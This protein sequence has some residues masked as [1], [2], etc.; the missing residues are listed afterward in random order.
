MKILTITSHISSNSH[1][2][3]QRN[4]TGFG[5]MVHDI[6]TSLA[7]N[8]N[9]VDV[10][11][12]WYRFNKLRLDGADYL[13]CSIWKILI[14]LFSCLPICYLIKHY[15]K[16]PVS[17]GAT[18]RMFYCWMLTGYY[19]RIIRKNNYDIVHIHGCG[20]NEDFFVK[21]CQQ[22]KQ[23]YVVTLH[24][25]NSFNESVAMEPAGKRYERDFLHDVVKGY[26]HITVIA[27]GIKKRILE[28]EHVK[29]SC[30]ID[31][32]CNAF[33]F[34]VNNK[35]IIDIREKIGIPQSAQLI[36][37]VGNLGVNKNQRQMVE[38][39]PLINQN[40]RANTYVLFIG[41]PSQEID[42]QGIIDNSPFKDQLIYAG[43]VD[44]ADI[45]AYYES[46][47]ATVLLSF[48]EGF[49]LSLVEG[50]H[51]G[52]PCAMFCDMDAYQDIYDPCAVIGI[53]KRSNHEVALGIE[54]L[55][56]SNWNR[57]SIRNYSSRFGADSM[58]KNYL[59]VFQS[60]LDNSPQ[61][62]EK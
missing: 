5:Y 53:P 62:N 49:G 46:A 17:F 18:I 26:H 36:L 20:I 24:G 21:L 48:S 51:F 9:K 19:K 10:L 14:S 57:D 23:K 50:M 45:P 2:C 34:S 30:Y 22:I 33:S 16:Y 40:L 37:Y 44:K 59:T 7:V 8:G 35:C 15:R 39:F 3:F 55:L 4:K 12:T 42:F 28:A 27:S 29:E 11:V 6:I 25:L 60:I 56:L 52:L 43:M 41:A 1:P 31:V 58:A 61:N 13:G 38:A 47:T 54:R 32:V